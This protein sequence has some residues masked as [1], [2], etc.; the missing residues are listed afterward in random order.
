[1][2]PEEI[3]AAYRAHRTRL[4]GLAARWVADRVEAEDVV[5]EV[6][7]AILGAGRSAAPDPAALPRYLSVATAN[8]ARS[9]LRHREVVER[10]Q[11]A[12]PGAAAS[13]EWT[14]LE[15]L[16]A[17]AVVEQLRALPR[18]QAGVMALRLDGL[19]LDE[20]AALLGVAAGTAK[21]HASRARHNLARGL[22]R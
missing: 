11:L 9:V 3:T 10:H 19:G 13:A 4:V 7:L 17:A 1:M 18:M 12:P 15:R 20:T 22:A 21:S 6:F 14:V 16:A 8:R 5:Q 2:T